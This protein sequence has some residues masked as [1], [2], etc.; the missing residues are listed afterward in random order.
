MK[1]NVQIEKMNTEYTHYL[2]LC[3]LCVENY[4]LKLLYSEQYRHYTAF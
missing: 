2:N 3:K 4:F 1:S